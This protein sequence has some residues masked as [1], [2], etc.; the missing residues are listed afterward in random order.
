M[1]GFV[2]N[3]HPTHTQARMAICTPLCSSVAK[4]TILHIF[5]FQNALF[6]TFSSPQTHYFTNREAFLPIFAIFVKKRRRQKR[7]KL[8]KNNFYCRSAHISRRDARPCV[9]TPTNS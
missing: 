4:R 3:P 5:D 2:H 8:L 1:F 9:S 6:Y 7:Q